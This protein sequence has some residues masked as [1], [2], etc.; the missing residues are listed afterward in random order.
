M[1]KFSQNK[2]TGPSCSPKPGLPLQEGGVW[3]ANAGPESS[4][5]WKGLTQPCKLEI[6]VGCS[7][8]GLKF[9][10]EVREVVQV[11]GH[12]AKKSLLAPNLG[13]IAFTH[14]SC[15]SLKSPTGEL[16]YFFIYQ[17]S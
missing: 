11:R 15:S 7:Q 4:G 13:G 1:T 2:T 6:E 12:Q 3:D 17:C 14:F 8:P 5:L 16:T 9:L 10:V